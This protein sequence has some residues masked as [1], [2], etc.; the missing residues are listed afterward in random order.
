[1]PRVKMSDEQWFN[2]LKE[3]R[4]S[5]MSDKDWCITHNIHPSTLY[6][7]IKR[8]RTQACEIPE[9][10][11]PTVSLKQEVVQVASIDK[12]GVITKPNLPETEQRSNI[13]VPV[14]PYLRTFDSGDLEATVRIVMPSGVKIEMSNRANAATIKS[15]LDVLQSV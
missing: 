4:S 9:H 6:K 8:L 1:M 3:C 2:F 15:I 12:N 7:A 10:T 13:N 14:T 5:G 11:G